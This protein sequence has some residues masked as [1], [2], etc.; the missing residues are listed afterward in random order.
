MGVCRAASQ[1]FAFSALAGNLNA[2]SRRIANQ[3]DLFPGRQ[4]DL[5]TV[6]PSPTGFQHPIDQLDEHPGEAFI[7]RI[8]VELHGYLDLARTSDRLPWRKLGAED[9]PDLTKAYTI[10]MR[11]NSM[12]RWLP[13]AEGISMRRAF[14]DAMDRLYELENEATPLVPMMDF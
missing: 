8:R 13:R 14:W 1:G 11:L 7:D 9:K 10:H 2:M 3:P 5:F 6:S 4:A 12:S